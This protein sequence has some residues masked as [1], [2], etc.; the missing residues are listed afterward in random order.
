MLYNYQVVDSTGNT[1]AGQLEMDNRKAVVEELLRQK[2]T[3]VDIQEEKKVTH[4]K[5]TKKSL[6][7]VKIKDLLIFTRQ[8]GNMITAGLP[9]IKC[10]QIL[11]DQAINPTLCQVANSVQVD[12]KSGFSLHECLAK[13]PH[14]FSPMYINMVKAGELGGK[15]GE[16]LTVLTV[17]LD[18]SWKISAK[19]KSASV[20]PAIILF[21]SLAVLI[22]ILTFVMPI[23]VEQYASSGAEL[24]AFTQFFINISYFIRDYWYFLLAGFILLIVG[25]KVIV[26][27]PK[28]RLFYDRVYLHLPVIGKTV[29]RV[30]VSHFTRILGAMLQSGVPILDALDVLKDAVGNAVVGNAIG[31]IRTKVAAGQSLAAPLADSKIFEPV[32]YNMVAV[33]EATGTLD[34]VLQ[35]MAIF[36][37]DEVVFAIDAALKFLEPLIL[38]FVSII[39]GSVIIATYLPVFNIVTTIG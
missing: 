21:V 23:F 29:N 12:L 22:F 31:Q 15:L 28:G 20:Y 38:I 39:I 34:D 24:P 7:K 30:S 18:R 2:Y 1:F 25:L 8:L 16:I 32:V 9:I 10:F 14:I 35:K 17:T 13:Y 3:I 36:Y 33:G 6:N 11:E 26:K 5:I 27:T 4:K 37:D 19:T